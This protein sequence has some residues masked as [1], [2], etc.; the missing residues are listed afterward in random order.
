MAG[1]YTCDLEAR[2]ISARW[3]EAETAEH[4]INRV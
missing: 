3:A 2:T 1:K 4:A